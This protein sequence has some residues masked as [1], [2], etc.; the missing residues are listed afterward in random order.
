MVAISSEITITT[1]PLAVWS[2]IDVLTHPA[3][4]LLGPDELGHRLA[5]LLERGDVQQPHG[6]IGLESPQD[7]GGQR[8][9]VHVRHQGAHD[10][11]P[12]LLGVL[13]DQDEGHGVVDQ[14]GDVLVDRGD[15]ERLLVGEVGVGAVVESPASRQTSATEVPR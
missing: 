9:R 8:V 14:A 3:L 2:G 11:P 5:Q 13:V 15:E 12:P 7:A 6:E 10:H 1:M 4:D